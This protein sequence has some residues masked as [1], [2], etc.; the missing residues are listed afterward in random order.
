MSP[1]RFAGGAPVWPPVGEDQ[2]PMMHFDFQVTD[3]DS[4]VDEAVALGASVAGEQPQ[5][6]VRVLIDPAGR[7]VLLCGLQL[8]VAFPKEAM[9]PACPA[10]SVGQNPPMTPTG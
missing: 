1:C 8:S 7:Q 4:A 6:N 10:R 2:R 9:I 3:L 5:E